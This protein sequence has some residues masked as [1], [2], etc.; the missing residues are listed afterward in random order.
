MTG[1]DAWLI[2]NAA[3]LSVMRQNLLL[4][5]FGEA[6]TVLGCSDTQLLAVEGSGPPSGAPEVPVRP[7]T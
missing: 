6:E 3:G 4:D 2:L 7:S 1:T 5:V